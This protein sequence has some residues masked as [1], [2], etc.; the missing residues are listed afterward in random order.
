MVN[1]TQIT[2][3][4]LSQKQDELILVVRRDQIF[5]HQPAWNGLKAVNF[6]DYLAIIKQHREFLP[7]SLMEQDPTY[8]QIIPYLV[9]EHEGRYFLM[10]R[11]AQ[12]TEKRLQNKYSLGIGGHIRQE[13]ME[14]DSLFDWARR[15]FHE[16][17]NYLGEFSIKPLGI[18]NDDSNAVGQVHI[19]FV[20]LLQGKTPN[21]SVKSELKSGELLSLEELGTYFPNMESW[22]Q[23]VV[24]F[25]KK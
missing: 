20:F 6:D 17:V 2:P 4:P 25:I 12:A 22:S 11:T 19:G 24:E 7:R 5:K 14:T 16:E 21:I 9:F 23:F 8:K 13:D 3:A 1:Q 18:L 10:Q 15:E